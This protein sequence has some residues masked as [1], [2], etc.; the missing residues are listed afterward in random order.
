[1]M[2]R[3]NDG[4]TLVELIITIA[5]G[6]LIT[7]AA[8]TTLLLGLRINAK[9]TETIIRQNTTNML[10]QVLDRVCNIDVPEN[11]D[12]PNYIT[13]TADSTN[14]TIISISCNDSELTFKDNQISLNG[15]VFMEDVASFNIKNTEEGSKL[16]TVQLTT[17]DGNTYPASVYCRT[18]VIKYNEQ[19]PQL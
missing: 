17:T 9:N 18:G 4:F 2:L 14:E 10:V 13:V 19:S 8:T 7:L 16:L 3:K 1:M 5:I 15:V 12:A 11:A 6:S